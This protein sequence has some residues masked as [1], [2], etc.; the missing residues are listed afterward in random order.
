MK[1][2]KFKFWY[3]F[4][5]TLSYIGL[6]TPLLVLVIM[7][8]DK[9]FAQ[10]KAGLSVGTGGIL[11]ILLGVL[12]VN[13]GFKKFNKVFWST[14]FL[15]CVYCLNSVIQDA[16][17]ITFTFWLGTIIYWLFEM[18]TN[19]YKKLLDIYVNEEIRVI[20][21]NETSNKDYNILGR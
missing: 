11:A 2:K 14:A 5:K 6:F 1:K 21:R 17:S 20:A 7:N 12:L 18:P 3:W 13:V 8:F 4:Y 9:Y 15:V 16:L 10:N 19:H